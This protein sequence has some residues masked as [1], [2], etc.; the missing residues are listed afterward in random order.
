LEFLDKP[1]PFNN[2]SIFM[3][4]KPDLARIQAIDTF[5]EV[6][7]DQLQWLIDESSIVAFEDGETMFNNGDPINHMQIILSGE[8]KMYAVIE[9]GTKFMN[10]FGP[11]TVTGIL[12]YSRLTHA[13]ALG[14][15]QGDVQMMQIDR[16]CIDHMIRKHYELTASL[17]HAMTTRVREF[18]QH[19]TQNEKLMALGKMSAGLAHELNNPAS[20]MA[21]GAVE[22][23]KHLQHV[24]EK[25]KSVI[26]I[27]MT[28]DHVDFVNAMMG[29][30]LK[31]GA[32]NL[33]LME[34]TSREDDLLDFLE[35]QGV[36]DA[37]DLT[38][39]LV[40]YGFEESHL[41]EVLDNTGEEHFDPVVH[42]IV[43]NLTTE[44]MVEEIGEAAERISGLIHSVKSFSYMDRSQ[45]FQTI[46]VHEGL[47][48]TLKLLEHKIQKQGHELD[49]HFDTKV[50]SIEA[51]PGELN[52]VWMNILSNAVDA[53]GENKGRITVTT[54]CKEDVVQVH[55]ADTGPG[56][57][58]D[59]KNR[60]FE[61]FFTTKEVGK[62]TGLGLDIVK[63]IINRHKGQIFVESEPG[64]TVF[65]VYIPIK[66][67]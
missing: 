57:P 12:P 32:V 2:Q 42:W 15:A 6:P 1:V 66:Q 25:F 28:E 34:R 5:K 40:D 37:E 67:Q 46:D 53:M 16:S 31:A 52:Q 4:A 36:E 21:R 33:T 29:D 23:R 38:G 65:K 7:A 45:D 22:L 64:N 63:K 55:L 59:V 47:A 13:K 61:P 8:I 24:P 10:S 14:I 9:S 62:G 41:E 26:K 49:T 19:Q 39:M 3:Q 48:S 54:T 51:M 18:T 44:K 35:D 56:I 50:P 60:I 43:S 58:T 11:D 27:K 17:V 30:H 20:A